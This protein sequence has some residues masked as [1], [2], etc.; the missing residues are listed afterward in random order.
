[1]DFITSIYSSLTTTLFF[2]YVIG[3]LF[4]ITPLYLYTRF[5]EWF[6]NKTS[7]F[8]KKGNLNEINGNEKYQPKKTKKKE[9]NAGSQEHFLEP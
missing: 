2:G 3:S 9:W 1:M 4:I 6:T 7:Y 5:Y 8:N